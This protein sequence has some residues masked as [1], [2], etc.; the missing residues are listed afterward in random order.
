MISKK[1]LIQ[2]VLCQKLNS[3]IETKNAVSRRERL[4]LGKINIL[5]CMNI[6]FILAVNTECFPHYNIKN[7]NN[8]K[9]NPTHKWDKEVTISTFLL[10]AH[11]YWWIHTD[12]ELSCQLAAV[13]EKMGIQ[14]SKFKDSNSVNIIDTQMHL[15]ELYYV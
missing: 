3:P 8:E 15:Q 10:L 4:E 13:C 9:V 11:K 14:P 2:L 1:S 12:K 6:F 5:H 7:S